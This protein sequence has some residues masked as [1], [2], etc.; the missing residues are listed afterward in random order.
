[1]IVIDTLFWKL[2]TV[3]DLVRTLSKKH[4]FRLLLESQHV[5]GHQTLVKSE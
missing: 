1:M 4:C 3:K 2:Q 5:K